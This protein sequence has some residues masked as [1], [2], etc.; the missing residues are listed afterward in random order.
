MCMF[1]CWLYHGR[2]CWL[3][4]WMQFRWNHELRAKLWQKMLANHVVIHDRLMK[5]LLFSRL[6]SCSVR[7]MQSHNTNKISC[8]LCSS[9]PFDLTLCYYEN[10]FKFSRLPDDWSRLGIAIKIFWSSVLLFLTLFVKSAVRWL[11][12]SRDHTFRQISKNSNE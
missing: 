2:H 11:A 1:S 4:E 12:F 9:F 5:S 3:H 6:F 7:I 8:F 10:H